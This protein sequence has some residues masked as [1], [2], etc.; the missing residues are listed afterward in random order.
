MVA[1]RT[2]LTIDGNVVHKKSPRLYIYIKIYDF[3]LKKQMSPMHTSACSF[4]AQHSFTGY[5]TF[6]GNAIGYNNKSLPTQ[7]FQGWL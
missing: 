1:L 2:Y 5:F 7:L 4:S 6:S 3:F